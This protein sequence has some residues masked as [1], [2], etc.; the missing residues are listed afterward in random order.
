MDSVNHFMD[1][2]IVVAPL[3]YAEV[4]VSRVKGVRHLL[5]IRKEMLAGTKCHYCENLGEASSLCPM[6]LVPSVHNDDRARAANCV[7]HSVTLL[8]MPEFLG[9]SQAPASRFLVLG[10]YQL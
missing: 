10:S 7:T 2:E 4:F 1:D 9:E 3:A 5:R 6:A 8:L